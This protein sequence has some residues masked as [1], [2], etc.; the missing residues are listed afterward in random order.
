MNMEI[1]FSSDFSQG[2]ILFMFLPSYIKLI[3]TL[4]NRAE[5]DLK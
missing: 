2:L 5:R 1:R 3:E 4:K